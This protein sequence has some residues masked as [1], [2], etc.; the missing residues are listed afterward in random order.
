V[1]LSRVRVRGLRGAAE[2]DLEIN[3]P[4]RFTVLAGANA[5]GKTTLADALY[6]AHPAGRFPHLPRGSRGRSRPRLSDM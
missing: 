5:A 1:H 3:L 6:L 2:G 4:G